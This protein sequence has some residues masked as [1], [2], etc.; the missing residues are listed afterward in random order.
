MQRIVAALDSAFAASADDFYDSLYGDRAEGEPTK[1]TR[2]S[3]WE[4]IPT[5][6]A[7]NA[8]LG[9]T[10]KYHV[11]PEEHE[12][13]YRWR[14]PNGE[15]VEYSPE[16][17]SP[18][19]TGGRSAKYFVDQEVPGRGTKHHTIY[20][21]ATY[22]GAGPDDGFSLDRPGWHHSYTWSDASQQG[23]SGIVES[24][25]PNTRQIDPYHGGSVKK[26]LNNIYRINNGE[27]MDDVYPP[28]EGEGWGVR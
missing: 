27:G 2:A 17:K 5:E 16:N 8:R 3:Q 26:I 1:Y 21:P 11:T 4:N 18:D 23:G 10:G 13:L 12:M 9:L 28:H 22:E 6:S 15:Q 19:G 7:F 25:W 20:P 24:Y 14:G